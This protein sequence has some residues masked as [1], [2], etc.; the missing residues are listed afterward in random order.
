MNKTDLKVGT[1]NLNYPINKIKFSNVNRDIVEKHSDSFKNKITEFG[2][3]VPIIIDDKGNLLEGHHR[4]LQATKMGIETLPAYIID[5]VDT[6]NFDEYQKY[7]MTINNNNRKWGA[8]DYL[9]SYS[10]TRKD[11]AYVYKKY[12]D[13]KDVFSVGNVLNIYFN[14]GCNEMFKTGN[15]IIRNR[16]FSEYLFKR[17]YDL[18]KEYGGV[19]IQAFTINRVCGIAHSNCKGN[20]KEMNF[21]FN[22]LETWAEQDNPILSS[23]EWIKPEVKKQISFYREIQNDKVTQ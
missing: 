5:W 9:K 13:T 21:I 12:L 8:Y 17:F 11:Y 6:T 20:T 7:V 19:K 18:K 10:Q 1:F 23:V 15:S 16:V 22:Q 3:L 2:W 4:V 14:N